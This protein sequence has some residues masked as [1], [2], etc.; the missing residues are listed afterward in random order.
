MSKFGGAAWAPFTS[1]AA[2]QGISDDIAAANGCVRNSAG[3]DQGDPELYYLHL[4]DVTQAD[5]NWHNPRVREEMARVVEF[6]RSKGVTGFR[7]DVINVIGK[8]EDLASAPE[9]SDDKRMYTDTPIVETYIRELAAHSFGQDPESVTVGEMSSTSI[10]RCIAYTRPENHGLS[11]VFN[12]HHLKVDYVDGEKWSRKPFDFAELKRLFAQWGVGMEEGGGW[13]ALFW[14]NHDQPRALDRFGDPVHYREESATMLA[15]TIH[16]MRGTP[17][18]YMGEEIG[19]TDPAY[20]Q[21]DD[22]V[23]IEAINAYR[24]LC[25]S[26]LDPRDAFAIVHSKARDNA[27]TPMQWDSTIYA[28]FSTHEPWLRPT[29][30]RDINVE[31]EESSG[32]VLSYYRTLIQLRK[33]LPVI[34]E[35]R[36]EPYGMDHPQVIAYVRSDG[37]HALFV[38]NNFY[39]TDTSIAVPPGFEG[40]QVLITNYPDSPRL[41]GSAELELRPYQSL[42][43]IITR[44]HV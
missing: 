13:N 44:S 41:L 20:T 17:F 12:F 24:E 23:D 28:G 40:A 19:M 6:W 36:Y 15:T 37:E 3:E 22:Y 7:F 4:Y 9:G 34:S 42:A 11:M 8:P 30:H 1:R 18:V 21:I 33:D 35:G 27:R 43:A 38:A 31:K 10:E 5:V 2:A 29:H 32:R 26:G 25:E 16:L 14:N 39:G